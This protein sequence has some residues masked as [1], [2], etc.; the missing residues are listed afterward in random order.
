M[1]TLTALLQFR[2]YERVAL[3]NHGVRPDGTLNP[4]ISTSSCDPTN[5][6]QA[7]NMKS[8]INILTITRNCDTLGIIG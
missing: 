6:R 1:S 3:P 8:A 5:A 7:L 2:P 4:R